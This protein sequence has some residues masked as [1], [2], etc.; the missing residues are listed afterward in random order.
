MFTSVNVKDELYNLINSH[1]DDPKALVD[2]VEQTIIPFFR[3]SMGFWSELGYSYK[4]VEILD[5]VRHDLRTKTIGWRRV[6]RLNRL[7]AECGA[8]KNAY[9]LIQADKLGNSA[10]TGLMTEV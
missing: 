5:R 10:W 7:I 4:A 3:L 1:S 2:C 6:D 8:L 9:Q